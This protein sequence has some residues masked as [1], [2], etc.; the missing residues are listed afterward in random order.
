MP[1]TCFTPIF[2]FLQNPGILTIFLQKT[3]LT[4]NFSKSRDWLQLY[5]VTIYLNLRDFYAPNMI[6]ANFRF[7]AKNGN[8]D[9]FFGK[10]GIDKQFW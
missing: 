4:S 6:Y 1:Q 3:G 8:F 2:V 10:N 5:Q 9:D 7:F